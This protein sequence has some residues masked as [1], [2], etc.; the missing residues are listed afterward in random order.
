MV[1]HRLSCL[2]PFERKEKNHQLRVQRFDKWGQ[3]LTEGYVLFAGT[4]VELLLVFL[5]GTS[6]A[7][8]KKLHT[9]VGHFQNCFPFEATSPST[10]FNTAGAL[11]SHITP[12]FEVVAVGRDDDAMGVAC[13][14]AVT[15]KGAVCRGLEVLAGFDEE[16]EELGTAVDDE[17]AVA[18]VLD[19][20]ETG[21]RKGAFF[22]VNIS[23]SP[24]REK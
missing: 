7:H 20:D 5:D 6:S 24:S 22:V 18:V 3:R 13:H 1:V 2:L 17:A 19:D 12:P 9:R 14:E 15:C 21:G 11:Q 23:K 10:V 16:E 8:W 4:V